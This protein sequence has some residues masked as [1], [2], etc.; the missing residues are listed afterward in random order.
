MRKATAIG[1]ETMVILTNLETR[2]TIAVPLRQAAEI[3]QLD[4][5]EIAWALE[6]FGQCETD[7][8]LVMEATN[9]SNPWAN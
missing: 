6:E 7:L 3:T 8:Y 1:E 2:Q 4:E 9:D 5:S